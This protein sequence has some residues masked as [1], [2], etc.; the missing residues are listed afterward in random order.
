MYVC[1]CMCMYVYVCVC[2]CELHMHLKGHMDILVPT[3]AALVRY[4]GAKA[5]DEAEA[6]AETKPEPKQAVSALSKSPLL[7]TVFAICRRFHYYFY[8]LR[9]S[10]VDAG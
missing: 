9:G 7:P 8:F 10:E 5:A 1:V 6:E 4:G 3:L 2:I